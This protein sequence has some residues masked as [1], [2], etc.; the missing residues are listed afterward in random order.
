MIKAAIIDRRRLAAPATRGQKRGRAGRAPP[1]AKLTSSD[2][3]RIAFDYTVLEAIMPAIRV[4]SPEFPP[5]T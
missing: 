4:T 1:P 5:E 2:I 3:R